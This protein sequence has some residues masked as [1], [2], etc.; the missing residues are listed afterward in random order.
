[1]KNFIITSINY[2]Y[3][4]NNYRT[5]TFN[6]TLIPIQSNTNALFYYI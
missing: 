5:Y 2:N 4:D 3:S 1:M 6:P